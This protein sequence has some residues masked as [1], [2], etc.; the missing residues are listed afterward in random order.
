MLEEADQLWIPEEKCWRLN[1]RHYGGLQGLVKS[2]VAEKVGEQQA[3]DWRR[4]YACQPPGR[5][6]VV[7]FRT[8]CPSTKCT[9]CC[10]RHSSGYLALRVVK[11]YGLCRH[12]SCR[13]HHAHARRYIALCK[14][15][16][17]ALAAHSAVS[18]DS[19]LIIINMCYSCAQQKQVSAL[20]TVSSRLLTCDAQPAL[21]QG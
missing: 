20:S 7:W 11:E 3:Q 17:F 4:S 6:A 12:G 15:A 1:E 13:A 21:L 9:A 2:E 8:Q 14:I 10:W 16:I 5:H 18:I 19:I